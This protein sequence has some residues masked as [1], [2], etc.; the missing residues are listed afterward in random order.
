ME[1]KVCP[2]CEHPSVVNSSDHLIRSHNISGKERKASLRKARFMAMSCRIGE[3]SICSTTRQ[4]GN[5]LP[6]TS[7]FPEQKK[8][9]NPIPSNSPQMRM[10]TSQFHVHMIV[11]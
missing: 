2:V 8:L 10:K 4:F 9:P 6:K 3:P 5:S 11:A 7:S 1:P